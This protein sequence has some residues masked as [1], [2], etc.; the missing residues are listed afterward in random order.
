MGQFYKSVIKNLKD[1]RDRILSG[2]VNCIPCPFKRFKSIWCGIER[3]KYYIVTAA[4]KVG[5]TM[6]TDYLFLYTPLVYAFNNPD[7]VRVKIFYFSLEM[8]KEE[9]YQ[10]LISYLLYVRSCGETIVSPTSLRSTSDETPLDDSIL[11]EVESGKYDEFLEFFENHVEI[12]S[13]V[14]HPTGIFKIMENYALNNGVVHKKNLDI[15]DPKTKEIT[16]QEVFSHYVPNDEDEYVLCIVDHI[17]LIQPERGMSLHESISR[18]SSEYMVKLRNNF[19]HIPVVVQQQA[20]SGESDQNF[21][22]DRLSP[23]VANLGDNKLTSRDC[24]AMFGIYS[25]F[26]HAKES[27]L[28]YNISKWR[29]NIRFLELMISRDGGAGSVMPL[30]FDG[31]V[32][33]FEEMPLPKD[34]LSMHLLFKKTRAFREKGI[35]LFNFLKTIKKWGN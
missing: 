12:I 32:N 3:K 4:Q 11:N 1:R 31:A 26:R 30:F 14:G 29:D 20:I 17:S 35:T 9:K 34:E 19:S 13:D 22:D 28:G 25:P 16:K 15:V 10:Q 8:S 21:K 6:L 2:K 5:K 24:N 7:K 18:L 33:F 23:S 27:H